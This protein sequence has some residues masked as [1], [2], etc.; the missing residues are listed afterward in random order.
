MSQGFNNEK[1]DL[2]D[3]KK[4]IRKIVKEYKKIKKY[5]KSPL[6]EVKKLSGDQTYVDKL[7][8]EYGVD[9]ETLK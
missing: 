3:K 8:K 9:P 2:Q 6:C 5:Q 1:D 7:L 4:A